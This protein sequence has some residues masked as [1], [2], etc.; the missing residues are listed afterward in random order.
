MPFNSQ[1]YHRNK[2]KRQA[3]EYL[4]AAR[5]ADDPVRR[6]FEVRLA[7]ASWRTYLGYLRMDECDADLKRF[8]KG[9]MTFQEFMHKWHP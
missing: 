2:A 6:A 7:R 8:R 5:L 9:E 1:S 4:A 3:R